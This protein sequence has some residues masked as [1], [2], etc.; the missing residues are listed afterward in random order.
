MDITAIIDIEELKEIMDNDTELIKECFDEFRNEWPEAFGNV[1]K[2][3]NEK[4]SSQLDEAAHKLKGTLRYL[5]AG[6]AQQAASDLE[7]AG[8]K[9]HI[10]NL[11]KKLALLKKKGLELIDYMEKY[12]S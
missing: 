4:N 10:E 11:E 6:P 5:A 8:K 12:G 7:T 2:A 1:E 3:V 9:Q